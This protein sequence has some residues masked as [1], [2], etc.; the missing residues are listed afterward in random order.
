MR[1]PRMMSLALIAPNRGPLAN[2]RQIFESY[3]RLVPCAAQ[4]IR[5]LMM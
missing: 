4:T 3:P 2:A 1:R 5:L